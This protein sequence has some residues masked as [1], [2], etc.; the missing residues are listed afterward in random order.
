MRATVADG[1]T[2]AVELELSG[3]QTGDDIEASGV[4]GDVLFV[5]TFAYVSPHPAAR[6]KGVP[7]TKYEIG[8]SEINAVTTDLRINIS[9]RLRSGSEQTVVGA[10]NRGKL[11][12]IAGV[13]IGKISLRVTDE[14]I[15]GGVEKRPDVAVAAI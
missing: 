15:S 10:I 1:H 13:I 2:L 5:L 6:L 8:V 12:S 9:M 11:P 7:V 4:I 14:Y 3:A